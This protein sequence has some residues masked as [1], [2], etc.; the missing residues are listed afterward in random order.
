M[1]PL[2]YKKNYKIAIFCRKIAK[3]GKR[4]FEKSPVNF[5]TKYEKGPRHLAGDPLFY[6]ICSYIFSTKALVSRAMTNSSLVG[7]TYTSMEESGVEILPS[8]PRTIISFKSAS[9]FTPRKDR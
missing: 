5:P 1:C 6:L 2:L 8:L 9:S 3:N 7:I 4:P